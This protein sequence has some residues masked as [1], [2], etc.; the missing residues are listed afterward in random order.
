MSNENG[1]RI[2]DRVIGKIKNGIHSDISLFHFELLTKRD[3]N[4]KTIRIQQCI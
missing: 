1:K 3:K 2:A 4:A